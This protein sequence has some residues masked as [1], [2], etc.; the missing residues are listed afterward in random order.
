LGALAKAVLES[1]KQDYKKKIRVEGQSKEDWLV[2]DYRD[3]V[4]RLFPR[5]AKTL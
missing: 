3:V 4:M 1:T 2:L 5:S